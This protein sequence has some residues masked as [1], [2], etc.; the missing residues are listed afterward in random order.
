MAKKLNVFIF[1]DDQDARGFRVSQS[2]I[3]RNLALIAIAVAANFLTLGLAL[4]WYR[5][6]QSMGPERLQAL[7]TELAEKTKELESVSAT[8]STPANNEPVNVSDLTLAQLH[9]PLFPK[10][11]AATPQPALKAI[12]VDRI[13]VRQNGNDLYLSSALRYVATDGGRQTGRIFA[14]LSG[15]DG[16]L[17]YPIRSW[18]APTDQ[19]WVN[20]TQGESFSVGKYRTIEIK[21]TSSELKRFTHAY[22]VIANEQGQPLFLQSERLAGAKPK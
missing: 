2:W 8:P 20:P 21:F 9:N 19:S 13:S 4:H 6:S 1:S 17:T 14:W 7:E 12:Q 18:N 5:K 3:E 11:D 15:P 16:T 22:L 10:A